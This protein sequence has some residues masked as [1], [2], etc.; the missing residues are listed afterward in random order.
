MVFSCD[1]NAPKANVSAY[2]LF[3]QVKRN[4]LMEDVSLCYFLYHINL[5]ALKYS[6]IQA[7]G[8][9]F[10]EVSKYIA[11]EYAALPPEEKDIWRKKAEVDKNRYFIELMNY[12]PPPGYDV[13][14]NAIHKRTKVKRKKLA[15]S[16]KKKKAKKL[17]AFI[18]YRNY[19][20]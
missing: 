13:F 9:S 7:P 19:C 4:S 5:I 20:R 18:H 11:A 6:Y 10:G 3:G 17:S 8:M 16:S 15:V 14:G 12:K 2:L 1:P